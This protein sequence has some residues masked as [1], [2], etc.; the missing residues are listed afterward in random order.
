MDA[1]WAKSDEIEFDVGAPLPVAEIV[2]VALISALRTS[3]SRPEIKRA[4]VFFG[5]GPRQIR[6]VLLDDNR[7][8]PARVLAEHPG[9]SPWRRWNSRRDLRNHRV[10]IP[11]GRTRNRGKGRAT[12]RQQDGTLPAAQALG[13]Y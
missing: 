9:A 8:N 5:F 13:A 6:S 11:R 2:A 3:G 12:F 1:V 7:A 4:C 10:L